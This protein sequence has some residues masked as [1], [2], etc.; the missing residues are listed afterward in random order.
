MNSTTLDRTVGCCIESSAHHE[1][2]KVERALGFRVRAAEGEPGLM[3]V[4]AD[5]A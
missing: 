5:L 1:A 4:E 2:L 3:V